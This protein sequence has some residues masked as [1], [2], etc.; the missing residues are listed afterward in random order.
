MVDSL[1]LISGYDPRTWFG[2][3]D[4]PGIKL[5]SGG[6]TAHV[7]AEAWRN[8]GRGSSFVE[9]L[10]QSG[11]LVVHGGGQ[12]RRLPAYAAVGKP[13]IPIP[14]MRNSYGG[15]ARQVLLDIQLPGYR[16]VLRHAGPSSRVLV[17]SGDT[18]L[19]FANRLSP[20]PEADI[21]VMGMAV[22]PEQATS[23]GVLFIP[24]SGG[25]QLVR[26]LQKPS[27]Q[28]IL[29][30]AKDHAFLVDTGMW[31][32][33]ERA[34]LTLMTRCGWNASEQ[35]FAGDSAGFYE[36][37]SCFGL[38]MGT[39]PV[40][41]DDEIGK[42]T[43]AA[44]SLPSPEF[45]HLGKSRDLIEAVTVLQNVGGNT[46]WTG[47]RHPD[48]IVQ[49]SEYQPPADRHLNH[50]LWIENST[51]PPSWRIACEH[52]LTGVPANSWELALE[53]GV[54]LDFVPMGDDDLCLRPYGIDD[55]F[56]GALGDPSTKWFGR[57]VAA[58]FDARGIDLARA[59]IDPST[60]IQSAE[61]FPV[62]RQGE[63][64]PE[65]VRWMFAS[66]PTG[67]GRWAESWLACKRLS[68]EQIRADANVRSLL[69]QQEHGRLVALERLYSKQDQGIFYRLD[70]EDTARM[71]ASGGLRA[72]RILNETMAPLARVHYHMFQSAVK[73]AA[74]DRDWR[75][76]E[77]R[78]FAALREAIVAEAQLSPCEPRCQVLSDQIV[79][80]RSPA[81]LD[82]AGG[83][84]DAPPYC[85]EH[86]GRVVNL[87][88]DLNGQ[89]PIQA[90]VKLCPRPEL[91]I[92]SI[93][94]G[95]E[96]TVRTY[97]ELDT[98]S[99]PGSEFA[100]AKAAVAVA[101][102]LPRFHASGGCPTLKELLQAFG[103]GIEISLLA[104][105][106]QGSGLGTS[107]ILAA[108]L[109]GALSALCGLGWD[110]QDIIVRTL[111]IEQMITT[112][113]GWQDQAGAVF[114]GIKLVE[115][116][117]GLVQ[118]PSPRWLP[119][120]LFG[121]GYANEVALLYYTGLT[122]LAKNI[123]REIVRGMFLN[124]SECLQIVDT[125]REHAMF[126]F[127]SI[128]RNDWAATCEAVK[129]SWALNQ[130][131]DSGTNPPEVQAIIK[132]VED[133]IAGCKLL[134]A[135]GG[136]YLLM[137]AKDPEAAERIRRTLTNDPPN[138]RARFVDISISNTGLE[139]TRS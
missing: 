105:I 104:A 72:S 60:D 10:R 76:D 138:N 84:T 23:F 34:V 136:G 96:H 124:S 97:E 14:V 4:P 16:R 39:D 100:L 98:F 135:G 77:E 130:R 6:G 89:P 64:D 36:L 132:S 129:I 49:N 2:T 78:S 74:G 62:V 70:L 48:Q 58:W 94:L 35:S 80:A 118:R 106:P 47:F 95:V 66:E 82:L 56:S 65:F 111:A 24:K 42:L 122:R 31:L 116:S 59:G 87:A 110:R 67:G 86:G 123:L 40:Q 137:L 73:R 37:Y 26:F 69:K 126:T 81:R 53:P 20:L 90:F 22:E 25:H 117:P 29:D 43:C 41:P 79:W 33:S 114:G 133:Y 63:L 91:L 51:V 3:S 45:Y 71:F 15:S 21:V 113:G 131:L 128:Q 75:A 5:G 92:H 88:V 134:G 120:K 93:D 83:W 112:G 18:L 119:D 85:M 68:A 13:F 17:A 125:I 115:T 99:Q 101:G 102:F 9:W 139:V 44:V 11:K 121:P 50:S 19:R 46:A 55:T 27:E 1:D 103:G 7:L 61:L 30:I 127:D 108:T 28:T 54:C 109:L 8:T 12:S 107:S 32:L 52:V 57:P 38:S